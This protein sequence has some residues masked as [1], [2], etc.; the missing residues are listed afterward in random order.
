MLAERLWFGAAALVDLF[1]SFLIIDGMTSFVVHF[2]DRV[3]LVSGAR[4]SARVW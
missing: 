4:L 3:W 1:D 2:V